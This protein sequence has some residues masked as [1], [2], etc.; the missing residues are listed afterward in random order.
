MINIQKN[1]KA[2]KKIERKIHK[3]NKIKKK[4]KMKQKKKQVKIFPTNIINTT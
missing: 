3:N 2:I 4:K 1:K